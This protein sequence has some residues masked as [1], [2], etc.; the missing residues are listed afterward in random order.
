MVK[1]S[2]SNH[3]HHNVCL[4]EGRNLVRAAQRGE[5]RKK[6]TAEGV[7]HLLLYAQCSAL[8]AKELVTNIQLHALRCHSAGRGHDRD[9]WECQKLQE[10]RES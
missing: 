5:R 8:S 3:T 7:T 1:H 9:L 10:S 6:R 4:E 2:I